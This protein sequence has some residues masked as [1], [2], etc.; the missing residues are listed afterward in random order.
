MSRSS[1]YP[2]IQITMVWLLQWPRARHR[3][4]QDRCARLRAAAG[5]ASGAVDQVVA[6]RDA[7]GPARRQAVASERGFAVPRPLQE[8]RAHRVEA[9]VAGQARVAIQLVQ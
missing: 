9:V 3:A 7:R 1:A 4:R 5:E 2:M 6:L 8:V